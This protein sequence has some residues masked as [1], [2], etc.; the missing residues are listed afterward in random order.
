MSMTRPFALSLLLVLLLAACQAK[1]T[2]TPAAPQAAPTQVQQQA[3]PASASAT[4]RAAPT[5]VQ[6]QAQPASASALPKLLDQALGQKLQA[7]LD[8]AV[9]SPDTKWPG[10]VLYVSAP[11]LGTWSGAAGLSEVATKTPTRPNDRFRAGS[12]TKPF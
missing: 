10:A 9:A 1:P 12:L 3:Q 7:A 6:Q 8:A 4:P 5:Q 11:G 2:P